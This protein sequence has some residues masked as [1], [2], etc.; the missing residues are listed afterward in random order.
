MPPCALPHC[1]TCTANVTSG[2]PPVTAA[3]E[4]LG[5]GTGFGN[6]VMITL[7]QQWAPAALLG[8]IMG[9]M[10]LASMGTFPISVALSGVLVR[11]LGPTPFFPVAG[12]VLTVAIL[13]ALSQREIRDFGTDV[14][15]P[16]EPAEP[17]RPARPAAR[18]EPA[19]K[20]V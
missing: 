4:L 11:V 20:S 12:A 9:V 3:Q 2:A 17:A 16:A 6:I 18:G 15:T 14:A 13:C 7:M 5:A 8:R 19:A 10:M 1:A